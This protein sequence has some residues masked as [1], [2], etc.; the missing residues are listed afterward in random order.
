MV[1]K[2]D[3]LCFEF[4]NFPRFNLVHVG[5]KYV[6]TEGAHLYCAGCRD[7]VGSAL[8]SRELIN[9]KSIYNIQP[10]GDK[11]HRLQSRN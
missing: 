8:L 2:I 5:G 6:P 1:C 4:H 3:W 11:C 10:R 7:P 9:H